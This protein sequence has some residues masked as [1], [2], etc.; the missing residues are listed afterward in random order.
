[1][2]RLKYLLI[3]EKRIKKKT[4]Q[5]RKSLSYTFS[6]KKDFCVHL[7]IQLMYHFRVNGKVM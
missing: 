3:V 7:N 1:M 6:I 4:K 2:L 5:R